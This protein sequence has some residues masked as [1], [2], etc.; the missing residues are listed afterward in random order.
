[1]MVIISS[2]IPPEQIIRIDIADTRCRFKITEYFEI[3]DLFEGY[4][5]P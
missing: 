4:Q 5:K 3:H 1:M 2:E